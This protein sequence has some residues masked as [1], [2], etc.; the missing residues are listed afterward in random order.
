[1]LLLVPPDVLD[2]LSLDLFALALDLLL[3][4]D[5]LPLLLPLRRPER[6]EFD[7]AAPCG[8]LPSR[9]AADIRRRSMSWNDDPSG[10]TELRPLAPR[11][12]C[13][14]PW[15]CGGRLFRLALGL[16]LDRPPLALC[17]SRSRS[18][19]AS[20]SAD[21]T[22]P[23]A[24]ALGWTLSASRARLLTS[25]SYSSGSSPVV[26]EE[27]FPS[28]PDENLLTSDDRLRDDRRLLRDD[29]R[30]FSDEPLLDRRLRLLRVLFVERVT[31]SRTCAIAMAMV[32]LP[33]PL[34]DGSLWKSTG[35]SQLSRRPWPPPPPPS[36]KVGSGS[37]L[38]SFGW[39]IRGRGGAALLIWPSGIELIRS[40][41]PS[42]DPSSDESTVWTLPVSVELPS[43]YSVLSLWYGRP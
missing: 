26:P 5:L 22:I 3:P 37:G 11:S 14:P 20:R 43:V 38:V 40:A 2:L 25:M 13:R 1:M 35:S 7:K 24:L 23:S 39:T 19:S 31:S 16:R 8:G 41:L 21:R 30:L 32:I 27:Y 6:V 34:E 12:R 15:L 17:L 42:S 18:I 10:S 29:L 9:V 28:S 4:L 36:A 33:L